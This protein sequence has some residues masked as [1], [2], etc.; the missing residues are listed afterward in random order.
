MTS[1]KI[2]DG[3]DEYTLSAADCY[4]E[5]VEGDNAASLTAWTGNPPSYYDS[6]RVSDDEVDDDI[7]WRAFSKATGVEVQI[8]CHRPHIP[9]PSNSD[10]PQPGLS[11]LNIEIQESYYGQRGNGVAGFC[12]DNDINDLVDT[13]ED[14]HSSCVNVNGDLDFAIA[15]SVCHRHVS[16]DNGAIRACQVEW[17][18]DMAALGFYGGSGD[19]CITQIEADGWEV[20]YCNAVGPT[21]DSAQTC[22]DTREDD[23]WAATIAK[24][25]NPSMQNA[26]VS[27]VLADEPTSFYIAKG[28]NFD[29]RTDYCEEDPLLASGVT[30]EYFDSDA[31]DFVVYAF[32]PYGAAPESGSVTFN[33][34]ESPELFKNQIRIGQCNSPCVTLCEVIEDVSV[35][36]QYITGTAQ[37]EQAVSDGTLVCSDGTTT[38]LDNIA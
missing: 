5:F 7:M 23:G 13:N 21:V 28:T 33:G 29:Q 8:I 2:L 26:N 38:C 9:W 4:A 25:P 34:G 6:C 32:I 35:S 15:L 16:R 10:D 37:L 31:E 22:L 20:A 3:G 12:N 27:P 36:A 1:V 17:C 18:D 11:Y 19:E 30:I 24:Y 14:L